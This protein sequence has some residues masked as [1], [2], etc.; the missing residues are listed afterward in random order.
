MVLRPGL[1]SRDS[2]SALKEVMRYFGGF[3]VVQTDGCSEFEGE[4]LTT[5]IG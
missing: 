5:L 2:A 1:T 4:F 3:Q